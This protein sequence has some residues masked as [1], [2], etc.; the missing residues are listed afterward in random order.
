MISK[1]VKPQKRSE[2]TCIKVAEKKN[3]IGKGRFSK[4]RL[5]AGVEAKKDG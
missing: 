2:E 4:R 1:E 3:E 5:D